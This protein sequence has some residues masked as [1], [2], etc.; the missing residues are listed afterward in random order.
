MDLF[1]RAH[2]AKVDLVD[3]NFT[4]LLCSDLLLFKSERI[5]RPL[6]LKPSEMS[7]VEVVTR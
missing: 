5:F 2:G 4:Q 6:V 1:S 7:V 3:A